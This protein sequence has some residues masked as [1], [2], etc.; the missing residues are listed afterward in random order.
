MK[1]QSSVVRVVIRVGIR[2]GV[3]VRVR[4]RADMVAREVGVVRGGDQV[5]REWHAHV[6]TD[7]VALGMVL[8]AEDVVGVS[9]ED[10][11]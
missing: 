4:V 6:L 3:R 8:E 1:G 10:A 9:R 5:V 11:P 7:R 2:V